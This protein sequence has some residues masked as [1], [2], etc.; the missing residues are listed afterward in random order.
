MLEV[1]GGVGVG[2]IGREPHEESH[3]QADMSQERQVSPSTTWAMELNTCHQAWQQAPL[4]VEPSSP[5][6]STFLTGG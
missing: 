1:M 4:P 6:P 3:T 5:N 2:L